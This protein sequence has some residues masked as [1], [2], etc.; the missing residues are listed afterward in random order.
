MYYIKIKPLRLVVTFKSIWS[1]LGVLISFLIRR[2]NFSFNQIK[3]IE[4]SLKKC[5]IENVVLHWSRGSNGRVIGLWNSTTA[6]K[7]I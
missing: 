2:Y 6:Y 4:F 3:I 7:G 1:L 5:W